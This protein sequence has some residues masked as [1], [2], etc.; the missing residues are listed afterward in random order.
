MHS[1]DDYENKCARYEGVK[2]YVNNLDDSIDDQ[3]LLKEFTP[4]G[5]ITSAKVMT[6]D[7]KSKQFGFV[8]FTSC[9]EA[10][11][12]IKEMHGR[13]VGSNPLYVARYQTKKERKAYKET[14]TQGGLNTMTD[15]KDDCKMLTTDNCARYQGVNLYVK[16]LDDSIDDE[17]LLKEFAPFG[18]I[19]SAK[20]MMDDGKSKHFGFVCFASSEDAEK[21]INKMHGRTVGSKPLYVAPSQTKEERKAYNHVQY[22]ERLMKKANRTAVIEDALAPAMPQPQ[23]LPQSFHSL[24]AE[25]IQQISPPQTQ[26]F[27]CLTAEEIRQT[28]EMVISSLRSNK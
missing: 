24:T 27:H 7:G 12:A 14:Q 20:V 2:L 22:L 3:R 17:R 5:T 10:Q 15:S 11:K 18:T 8:C 26:S 19:T 9:K 1:K 16:N 6:E 25:E 23:S 4:F 13:I 21:A 28:T